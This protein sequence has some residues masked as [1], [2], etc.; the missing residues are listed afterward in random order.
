MTTNR[1]LQS[2]LILSTI[3][4]SWLGMQMVHEL[5]HMSAA[6]WIGAKIDHI[7]L[8]PLT[9]SHTDVGPNSHPLLVVWAGP[10]VGVTLPLLLWG[11]ALLARSKQSFL[12]RFFAGFCLVANGAYIGVGS[13]FGIGDCG[14]MLRNGSSEWMLR[15]FG[16]TAAVLGFTLWN[17]QG[18]HFGL[19]PTPERV[20]GRTVLAAVIAFAS[21]AAIG[22]S[23]GGK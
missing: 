12:L 5:G 15:T 18:K 6:K 14:E 7:A 1:F 2:L 20:T 23:I 22:L 9:I 11:A 10:V 3:L 16:V 4:A 13:F 21:L 19:V 17:G 8:H